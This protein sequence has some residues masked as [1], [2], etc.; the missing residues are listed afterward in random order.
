MF[1]N[2]IAYITIITMVLNINIVTIAAAISGASLLY[3]NAVY[4]AD[5]VDESETYENLKAKYDLANPTRNHQS[6][7][8]PESVS[9]LLA[10]P[11]PSRDMTPAITNVFTSPTV[12]KDLKLSEKISDS[13]TNSFIYQ[14][15]L[16]INVSKTHGMPTGDIS[17][18]NTLDSLNVKYLQKG[19]RAFVRDENGK[20]VLKYVE[21]SGELSGLSKTDM[22]S[23]ESSDGH[24]GYAFESNK[25]GLYGDNVGIYNEGNA[26]HTNFKDPATSKSASARGYK[27]LTAGAM[28]A[29]TQPTPL[30]M[31][32]QSFDALRDAQDPN[33][34]FSECT[35]ETI[36]ISR[37]F[38]ST[39]STEYFCQDTN[40]SNFDFC[41]V[42]RDIKIPVYATTPGLR[43]CG[44]G[45]Y[46]FD[47][48]IDTWKTSRCRNT[49]T[50]NSE[51]AEFT[52]SLNMKN[53]FIIKSV[54]IEGVASDHF[55][56]TLN[57]QTIWESLGKTQ[58]TTGNY[59]SGSCNL[60]SHTHQIN[61]NVTSRVNSIVGAL[62]TEGLVN[63]DFRADIR[64]KRSGG[65]TSVIRFQ[66]EDTSGFG[67]ESTFTQYPENCYDA[68]T[69]EDKLTRGLNGIYDWQQLGIDPSL[70]P[71]RYSCTSTPR[72]PICP[73]GQVTFGSAGQEQCYT[74][75]QPP[76]CSVG[77]YNDVSQRCEY[78]ADISCP[79]LSGVSCGTDGDGKP[80][81][82][83]ALETDLVDQLCTYTDAE[84]CGSWSYELPANISCPNGGTLDGLVC[85]VEGDTTNQCDTANGYTKTTVLMDGEIY[86]QCQ[87]PILGFGDN[88]WSCDSVDGEPQVF[89][90]TYC[91]VYYEDYLDENGNFIL[92]RD[93]NGNLIPPPYYDEEGEEIIF[94]DIANCV[95]AQP[96]PDVEPVDFPS[97]FCTF[98]EYQNIVVGPNG[99]PDEFLTVI[100][101]FYN[102]DE[103]DKTWKVNL[104]GYRCDPTNGQIMC[105]PDPDTGEEVC[106]DWEDL[107]NLPDRCARYKED[108]TC[109]EVKRECTEGWLEEVSGR[110][111]ADTVTY[112]CE[113][114]TVI[115]YETETETTTC[116]SMLPCI[117]GDCEIGEPEQ[118]G[119]FVEALVAGSIL[120]NI[121]GD[122]EC[123]DPADP[124][125]CEIFSGEY[126]YCSWETTGLGSDCCEEVG[127]MDLV[128]YVS[129]TRQML[130]V[131][132]MAYNGAFGEGVAGGYQQLS[133]PVVDGYNAV[134]NW[135]SDGIRSASESV[136]GNATAETTNAL[137]ETVSAISDGVSAALAQIQQQVYQFVYDML[138]DQLSNMIFTETANVAAGEAS[139]LAM[140]ETLTNFMSNVMAVYAAYQMIKLALTLLTACDENEM[141]MGVKL[142]QRQC[143]KVGA[144][145]CS[146]SYGV[147]GACMQRRQS[148][149]CF[150]SI[151]AR[152]IVKEAYDQLAI[153]PLPY[154]NQ[155]NINTY[156]GDESCPGLTPEQLGQLDFSKPSMQTALNEWIGLLLDAGEIPSES[157]EQSLTGGAS[158]SDRDCPPQQVPVMS[159]Y[160][161]TV[162][163]EEI[164]NQARD[165]QGNLVYQTIEGECIKQ[166]QPGQIWNA[167]ERKTA[168]ERTVGE[169]GY[170]EGAQDRQ[171][172]N[173]QQIKS[174][175]G[176][177]DCSISPR[178]PVCDF[179]FNPSDGP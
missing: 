94:Q 6:D 175:L 81:Y 3:S 174:I 78:A 132:Q 64:W 170:I 130:K 71:I 172:E 144:T 28:Q 153:N 79:V 86:E 123:T 77:S 20:L 155:P 104:L 12:T 50:G 141:D 131:N 167:T 15:D 142:A 27:A 148:Y 140:N 68:L 136:F 156:E 65:M 17:A 32:S 46:E 87:G 98:D 92:T 91:T 169:G 143:F 16:A 122:S 93:E 165:E 154:G 66:I 7:D 54:T 106:Y 113:E 85:Y 60:H 67:L 84:H 163:E 35:T 31:L 70:P 83:V 159:C 38:V 171:S 177:I 115:N 146:K 128:G 33:Q 150:S 119:K 80:R 147:F 2:T 13:P 51:P 43:S 158:L 97:S 21:G 152:I 166:V 73:N 145:F 118:N 34:W 102:G 173:R 160:I 164:C 37:E 107:K 40:Q 151:L 178:P 133:Q 88:V 126:K 57:G 4:A 116:D 9:N 168:S 112:R 127:G 49:A 44:V 121:E 72:Q 124:A 161:D 101:P 162:T 52:L 139:K 103:G 120:D 30:T 109:A 18:G 48:N 149:C 76:T 134:A 1:K 138:P 11:P 129:F 22:F 14:K 176:N 24:P 90:S 45:C 75:P 89:N 25:Q 8:L 69:I 96:L 53:S 111:M 61:T 19:T 117:G 36:P 179:G 95:K 41:E 125:T 74:P 47:M 110:C 63:L 99:L 137:G 26:A 10:S 56:Y 157:D 105:M 59:N 58:G 39:T 135:A 62:P 55:K 29:A 42:E 5:P 100:P 23:S 114:E 108:P 82:P